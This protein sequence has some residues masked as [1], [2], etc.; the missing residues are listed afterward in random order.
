MHRR[1]KDFSYKPLKK[2]AG[3]TECYLFENKED[4]V[5]RIKLVIEKDAG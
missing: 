1:L 5:S 2:F 3:E 4:I